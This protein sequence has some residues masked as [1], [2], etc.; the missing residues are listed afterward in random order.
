MSTTPDSR[1]MGV[2]VGGEGDKV[3][4][5]GFFSCL[6]IL[7]FFFFWTNVYLFKHYYVPGTVLRA[8]IME[9]IV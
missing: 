9:L 8:G 4:E 5:V 7:F 1:M 6:F 2:G 3:D